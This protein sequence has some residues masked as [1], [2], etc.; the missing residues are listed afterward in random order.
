[1]EEGDVCSFEKEENV[2]S[3]AKG[4]ARMQTNASNAARHGICAV[5]ICTLHVRWYCAARKR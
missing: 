3:D 5:R 2:L 1:M 4:V